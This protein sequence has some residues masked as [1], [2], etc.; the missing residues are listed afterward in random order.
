MGPLSGRFATG[1]VS[2]GK[3]YFRI[4]ACDFPVRGQKAR[5]LAIGIC[6]YALDKSGIDC[7]RR[8]TT[9]HAY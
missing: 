5:N 1:A 8:G 6:R 2:A 3:D 4:A 9:E 7:Y